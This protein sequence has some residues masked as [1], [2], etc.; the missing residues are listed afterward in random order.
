MCNVVVRGVRALMG[1]MVIVYTLA[2]GTAA[3]DDHDVT[4]VTHVSSTGLDL[5]R[6]ADAEK[7]Y[8][9]LKRAAA[10]VC[11]DRLRVDLVPVDNPD[12]CAEKALSRAVRSINLANVTE[13]YLATHTPRQAAAAGISAALQAAARH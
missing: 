9:R 1:G 10:D 6:P 12:A 13:V 7:F 2:G 3:A 11:T 4:L 5:D 8:V